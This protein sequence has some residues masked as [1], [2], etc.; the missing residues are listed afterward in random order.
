MTQNKPP[1]LAIVGK[2][3]KPAIKT[4]GGGTG[5]G[6]G[7]SEAVSFSNYSTNNGAF[8]RIKYVKSG[9]DSDGRLEFSLCNFVC[10]ITKII[11]Q[12]DG[13]VDTSFVRIEGRRNDGFLL[14]LVDVP[15][16]EFMSSRST[17]V[18]DAWG[19]KP[20]IETGATVRE[21]LRAAIQ[22]YS[23]LD[24][25][26]PSCTVYKYTGWKKLNDTWHYLTGSGAITASGLVENVEVDLGFNNM[27]CYQLPA[28][29]TG[30]KLTTAA[31]SALLLLNICPKKPYIGLI[32]LAAIARAPLGE[33]HPTDFIIWIQSL[34]GCGKSELAALALGFFGDFE[35]RNF[36][37]NW[38]DSAG[39]CEVKAHRCKDSLFVID[40]YKPS[41]DQKKVADLKAFADRFI[42]NTG[43]QSGRD[44][45]TTA[46]VAYN[47]SMTIATG[48][49]LPPGQS[50]LGRMLVL[51]LDRSDI[52][53]L[54]KDRLISQLQE[55]REKGLFTGLMSAYLQYLAPRMDQLKKDLPKHVKEY[56]DYA[57]RNKIA[58][59]HNRAPELYG[60]LYAALEVFTDF[61]ET[62]EGLEEPN[63]LMGVVDY[64]LAQVFSEQGAYQIEQDE[65]EKF[66]NL[67]RAVLSTGCGH[68]A[69][70][71]DQS[72]PSEHPHAYGWR[73]E[74]GDL[75]PKGELIGWYGKTPKNEPELWLSQEA[76]FKAV[77]R[78]ARDQGS[79]FLMSP[80][81]LWRRLHE[82]G[83]II[84][85]EPDG[86]SGR[87]RLTVKKKT[88]G[89]HKRVMVLNPNVIE[90]ES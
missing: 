24:G 66:L 46:R 15:M 22:L 54:S 27:K 88:A 41:G 71:I 25:D 57:A 90:S 2:A 50:N 68:V 78:F 20:Y 80:G 34:T 85:T 43:N 12:D 55:A 42:M 84:Q 26:V 79:P 52:D 28:P 59:S 58:T 60:N 10:K 56:R 73:R 83:H 87:P 62:I 67:L 30:D 17:W 7:K 35:A 21:N 63:R 48:E 45:M 38:G 11:I 65:T 29:L 5:S 1:V 36:P 9:G 51:E 16:K 8:H 32:L 31:N 53:L 6:S 74:A 69:Y 39:Q 33:C 3:K 75:M 40:E 14:T 4:G 89:G 37:A 44:V 82:K 13:L 23:S 81:T 76:V 47:R 18:S 70:Y 77:Q 61:L 19:L 72:A 64:Q 49:D 86:K